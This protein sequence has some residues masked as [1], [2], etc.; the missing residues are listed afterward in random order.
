MQKKGIIKSFKINKNRSF[1]FGFTFVETIISITIF[2]LV[3]VISYSLFSLNQEIWKKGDSSLEIFQ[4]GR[5]VTDR[6]VREIRQ[7]KEITTTLPIVEDD[8]SLSPAVELLFHD[9]HTSSISESDNCQG[10]SESNIVLGPSASTD[11]GYYDEMFI[12]IISGEGDD[13]IRK[14]TDYDGATKTATIGYAWTIIPNSSSVYKI[15]TSYYYIRYH[16][17]DT[18]IFRKTIVYYFSDDLATPENEEDIFVSWDSIKDSNPPEF[19][20]LEDQII[21]EYIS[22]MEFWGDKVINIFIKAEK[23]DSSFELKT[24]VLGRNL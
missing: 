17:I 6:L 16:R 7:A 13:Q 10:A 20:I 4:N 5:I 22:L 12:K 14:I 1:S 11:D 19:L 15:D 18:E 9:G 21:A 23:E 2:C 8:P 24:K 3:L